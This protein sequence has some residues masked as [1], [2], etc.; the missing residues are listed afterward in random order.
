MDT[1]I[2]IDLGTTNSEVAVIRD[3]QPVVLRRGRR[4]DPAVGRRPRPPGPPAGRQ[5]RPEP[6][7]PGAGADHPVDQAED[8]PGGHG[9]PGR[10]EV[11]APGNLGDHPADAQEPGREGAGASGLQGRDHGPRLLQRRPAPGHSRG[12]RARRAGGRSHHQRAD[13]RRAD[14]RPPS[15]RSWNGC[16]S[17]TSAAARSTSRSPRSRT[18]SSRSSPATATPSSAAT[19]S[20][21]CCSTTSAIRFQTEARHRP[22]RNR[23]APS[24]GSCTPSRTPRKRL[25]FEAVTTHRGR[26]HRREGRRAS[27]PEHGDP[28]GRVRRADPPA[29]EQDAA[30]P[31][32]RP[33]RRQAAGQPDRQ[34]RAGRRRDAHARWSTSCS[35]SGSAGRCTPRSSPTWPSPWGRPCRAG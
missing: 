24:L 14:L 27:E 8:G 7:R 4:P 18:A 21:S 30:L 34:G 35:R 11:H 6:V 22:P 32:R 28:S 12:G 19:T 23:R 5:G 15:P 3:G 9:H 33:D 1:I 25:S 10:P 2:G 31:R 29:P 17:T 13:R 20:T 16:W 26:V